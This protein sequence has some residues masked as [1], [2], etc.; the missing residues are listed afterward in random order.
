MHISSKLPHIGTTIFTV[1][2]KMAAD[3]NA[4]NLSQGFPNFPIDPILEEI[5]QKKATENVHQYAPMSG[6]PI[7]L[8]QIS[9]V[10][11]TQYGRETDPQSTILVTAGAT[12]AIFTTIQ[13]LVNKNEDVIILDPSYDCYESPIILAGA[14]PIRIP[15]NQHFLPD[16]ET[17]RKT[18]SDKTRLIITNNP[19]NPSGTVWKQEDI[20]ELEK[21]VADFPNLIILS[22][23]VYEFLM[24]QAD[25]PLDPETI[26]SP[27]G[28]EIRGKAKILTYKRETNWFDGRIGVV[29]D[30]TGKDYDKISKMDQKLKNFGYETMMVL[31]NT[32]LETAQKRNILR[33]R[34]LPPK[35]VKDMWQGV[36]NNIGKFQALFGGQNMYIIDNSEA[37]S[38]QASAQADKLFGKINTWA[39]KVPTNKIAQDWIKSQGGR[40]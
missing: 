6:L 28:Q 33:P 16:W 31:V 2:S 10:V 9:E 13:A 19:H 36:Q 14:K 23:E 26:Y 22:D 34:K 7:L 39:K 4:I 12:Q 8:D 21:L 40:I 32:D 25:L 30:G 15:L 24:K 37:Q 18:V 3:Y 38:S 27:K 5:V 11:A 35:E 29:M 20:L 17:I 1:M